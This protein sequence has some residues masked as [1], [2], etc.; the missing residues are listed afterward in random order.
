MINLSEQQL[1][2]SRLAEYKEVAQN[3]RTLT[4]IRFKL[5]GFLPITTA[6]IA[7]STAWSKG[8]ISV[9]LSLFGLAVTLALIVY[10]ERNNQLYDELVARGAELERLLG[11]PDGNFSQ[12]PKAWL[13]IRPIPVTIEHGWPIGIIYRASIVAWLFM[14]FSPFFHWLGAK[15]LSLGFFHIPK[16]GT[17]PTL[18]PLVIAL[19]F[20]QLFF[21]WF[22]KQRT[23]REK[24]MREQAVEAVDG[25]SAL[26]FSLPQQADIDAWHTIFS[27]AARLR[28][29]EYQK[30]FGTV[31]RR[32]RFYLS[33]DWMQWKS[34]MYYP[35][36]PSKSPCVFGETTAAY[37]IGLVT[38]LPPRWLIDVHSG[39]RGS[40]KESEKPKWRWASGIS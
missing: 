37:I 9:P 3:F 10:N 18:L 26:K 36:P 33:K 34:N 28:G 8:E 25:L 4:E 24:S 11:L 35:L 19:S 40:K 31:F 16:A 1:R 20:C 13:K 17:L 6:L 27:N 15:H 38:D 21:R 23:D 32:A 39:R 5:L 29:G 12:R 2:E 30:E 22:K 7:L 14:L